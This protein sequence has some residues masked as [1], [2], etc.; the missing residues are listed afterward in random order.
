MT[1]LSIITINFNNVDGLRRTIESVV[2]QTYKN[3]QYIV[4]DGDSSDGSKDVIKTYQTEIDVAISEPDSGIYNAMNKGA[5][6]AEGEYLLFLN[7][8]DILLKP[9]TIEE[10]NIEGFNDEIVCGKVLNHSAKATYLKTPPRKV[11]LYTFTG[12][13]LPH[14]S[15]FIKK[16][17][18]EKVGGYIESYRIIS[19]WCFFVD[20]LLVYNCSYSTIPNII[21]LFEW[22]GISST[23]TEQEDKEEF[24]RHRFGRILDD[25]LPTSDEAISNTAFWLSLKKGFIGKLYRI[26]FIVINRFL[27]LRNT[28]SRR[29]GINK[30]SI[31]IVN[32]AIKSFH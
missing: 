12:G 26:P 31:P 25:Y 15:S 19:D 10:L 27:C 29:I 11:S 20:A 13:S 28:L 23:S 6:L 7:S 4:I 24:L 9:T 14:P 18:F 5:K 16:S 22:G 21:T 17:I 3:I 8:G 1:R 30:A 32:D 2:N